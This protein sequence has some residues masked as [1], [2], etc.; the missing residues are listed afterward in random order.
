MMTTKFAARINYGNDMDDWTST[1]YRTGDF[2]PLRADCW[3]QDNPESAPTLS[4][5]DCFG[6][7]IN[8]WNRTKVR[9]FLTH[10]LAGGGSH[11]LG[12]CT[13]KWEMILHGNAGEFYKYAVLS[14]NIYLVALASYPTRQEWN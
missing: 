10:P 5:S 14:Y 1:D 12:Y 11:K 4:S 13:L 6:I 7:H 9:R 8:I 3:F 2:R